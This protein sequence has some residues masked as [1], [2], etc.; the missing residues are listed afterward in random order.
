MD[1]NAAS[2]LLIP[3]FVGV[4]PRFV[5]S[6]QRNKLTEIEPSWTVSPVTPYREVVPPDVG[7]HGEHHGEERALCT[8]RGL[9]VFAF[10]TI[11]HRPSYVVHTATVHVHSGPVLVATRAPSPRLA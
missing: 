7:H 6:H 1:I 11:M 4:A 3:A 2:I 9:T 5:P 10:F 8:Y